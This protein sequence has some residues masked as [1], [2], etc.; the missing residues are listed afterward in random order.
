MSLR[1]QPWEH[2]S[3]CASERMSEP[4]RD[5]TLIELYRQWICAYPP[6]HQGF[7]ASALLTFGLGS[8]VVRGYPVPSRVVNPLHPLHA[9]RKL[10]TPSCDNQKCLQML[11]AILWG[12]KW[13]WMEIFYFI[14]ICLC[15]CSHIRC[16][17]AFPCGCALVPALGVYLVLYGSL[18][19]A[20]PI[21]LVCA[22][23]SYGK[24]L[25]LPHAVFQPAP[26][27]ACVCV[28]VIARA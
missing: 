9:S 17:Y 1:T 22:W 15:L 2:D 10:P 8:L 14:Q 6:L 20:L 12:A 23:E 27:C 3:A 13:P 25:F 21:L 16:V 7:L 18:E 5:H 4:R 11:P 26:V 28:H 24:G 19:C